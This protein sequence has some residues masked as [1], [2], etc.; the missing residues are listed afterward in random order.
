[1]NKAHLNNIMYLNN[2]IFIQITSTRII[3]LSSLCS[4][5]QL[6]V[7]SSS[8]SYN[9]FQAQLRIIYVMLFFKYNLLLK[10]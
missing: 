9:L 2:I 6:F 8:K 10:Y 1:M 7:S 4:K 3:T 5:Y